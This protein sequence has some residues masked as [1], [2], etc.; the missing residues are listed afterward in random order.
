M[1]ANYR[2]TK[3]IGDKTM[4]RKISE[5]FEVGGIKYQCIRYD[6][7]KCKDCCFNNNKSLCKEQNCISFQREDKEEVIFKEIKE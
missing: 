3:R 5:I 4:E 6:P 1:D 2:A 7:S